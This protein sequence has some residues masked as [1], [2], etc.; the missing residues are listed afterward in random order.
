MS[1]AFFRYRCA[2]RPN[3]NPS[4]NPNPEPNPNPDPNRD[5]HPHLHLYPSPSPHQVHAALPRQVV[6][7]DE[8]SVPGMGLSQALHQGLVLPCEEQADR[9]TSGTPHYLLAWVLPNPKP[10]PNPS[11]NP[12]PNPNT[13]P[14]SNSSPSPSPNPSPSPS[15]NPNP[16]PHQILPNGLTVEQD[17]EFRGAQ[18]EGDWFYAHGAK[19][20]SP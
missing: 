12:N 18:L 7:L 17:A 16:N 3:P 20:V 13:N 19:Q 10:K 11:P 15:P 5:P 1:I 2:L 14:S 4:P 9:L 6:T 8:D